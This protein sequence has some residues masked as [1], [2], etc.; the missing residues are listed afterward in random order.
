MESLLCNICQ[1]IEDRLQTVKIDE[2]C[3][4]IYKLWKEENPIN[5]E[6]TTILPYDPDSGSE[7]D[8]DFETEQSWR[9]Q[10]DLTKVKH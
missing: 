3:P 4:H 7:E 2:P 1:S 5:W 9:E 6:E 10:S 8:F